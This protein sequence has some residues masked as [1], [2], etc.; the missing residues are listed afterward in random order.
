[1]DGNETEA[2][3]LANEG[4]S[5]KNRPD[6]ENRGYGISTSKRMLVEG[7]KGA[8]F[9]LS[10]Q[11]FHRFENAVNDYIDLH[12]IF[13]WDGTLILLRIPVNLPNDF[14][15]IDYLE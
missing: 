7:M 11:A 2:L 12:N 5:T 9:M 4:Y 10:G 8:F 15:Y 1:M 13:R 14:N 6:A 3:K